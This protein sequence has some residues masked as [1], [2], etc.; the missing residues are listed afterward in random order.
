M[1]F[2]S[3][4]TE[5]SIN[6]WDAQKV[7]KSYKERNQFEF[8]LINCSNQSESFPIKL[9]RDE[10]TEG[11]SIIRSLQQLKPLPD[12]KAY[13]IYR[14]PA[15]NICINYLMLTNPL[16]ALGLENQPPHSYGSAIKKLYFSEDSEMKWE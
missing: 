5:L 3:I 6:G 16:G 12:T 1:E 14:D 2:D 13:N 8:M 4:K 9:P 10:S 7:I 11:M 15:K